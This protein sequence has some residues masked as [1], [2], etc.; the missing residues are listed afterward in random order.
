MVFSKLL[1]P[2]ASK[3][4]RAPRRRSSDRRQRPS[5]VPPGRSQRLASS[6]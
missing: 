5:Q 6:V 3:H 2:V 1:F 4:Q